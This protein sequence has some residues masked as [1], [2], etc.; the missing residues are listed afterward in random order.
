[1][2][3]GAGLLT[4]NGQQRALSGPSDRNCPSQTHLGAHPSSTPCSGSSMELTP[5]C[6]HG[7]TLSMYLCLDCSVGTPV[8]CCS[9]CPAG[10]P[11]QQEPLDITGSSCSQQGYPT[12]VP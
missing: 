7:A 2:W 1:M 3:D 4:T 6:A 10:F 9:S 12:L 8:S 11:R 5:A